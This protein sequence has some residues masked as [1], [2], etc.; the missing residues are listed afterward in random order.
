MIHG[1]IKNRHIYK[2]FTNNITDVNDVHF[3]IIYDLFPPMMTFL[4]SRYQTCYVINNDGIWVIPKYTIKHMR[5]LRQLYIVFRRKYF[6][7]MYKH[8]ECKIN[9]I[10]SVC[11]AHKIK[12]SFVSF[13]DMKYNDKNIEM[14]T[15]LSKDAI[16]IFQL[17]NDL[18]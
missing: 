7:N 9:A 3:Y 1:T 17:L 13:S 8:N 6:H 11:H 18:N 10:L 15:N 12:I 2:L 4:K 5:V 16:I 14:Y